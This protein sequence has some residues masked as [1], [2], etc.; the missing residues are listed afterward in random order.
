VLGGRG[1]ERGR[2]SIPRGGPKKRENDHQMRKINNAVKEKNPSDRGVAK[3]PEELKSRWV[4]EKRKKTQCRRKK[5]VPA[6][7]RQVEPKIL[8][9]KSPRREKIVR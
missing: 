6:L 8:Q 1:N 2:D 3:P 4:R 5:E 7:K 9:P